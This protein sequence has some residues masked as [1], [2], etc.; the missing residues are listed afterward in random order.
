M[1]NQELEDADAFL[2]FIF[3]H[4]P[5]DPEHPDRVKTPFGS[6]T[7]VGFTAMLTRYDW[8]ELHMTQPGAY[9]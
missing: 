5:K 7:K 2:T 1:E 3:S 6:K 8:H 9:Q 4:L